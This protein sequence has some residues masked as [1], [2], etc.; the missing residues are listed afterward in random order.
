VHESDVRFTH[1]GMV[2]GTPGYMAPELFSMAE[3]APSHDLYAAGVVAMFALNGPLNLRDGAFRAD[4]LDHHL[5]SVTPK[6]AAVIRKLVAPQ[7]GDR[8][9]DAA[10]VRA[11]LPRVP[12]DYPLSFADGRPLEILD[13]LPP[14]AN[15]A[16]VTPQRAQPGHGDMSMEAIRQGNLK[17]A[18]PGQRTQAQIPSPYPSPSSASPGYSPQTGPRQYTPGQSEAGGQGGAYGSPSVSSPPYGTQS[19]QP[20]QNGAGD[21]GGGPAL[22]GSAQSGGSRLRRARTDPRGMVVMASVFGLLAAVVLGVIVTI[23]LINLFPA[24]SQGGDGASDGGS[25]SAVVAMVEDPVPDL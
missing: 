22:Q 13:Q 21:A 8:Y 10:S 9:Q 7:P 20:Q 11:D 17:Q 18:S 19:A 4:E 12:P 14:L 1:V 16:P 24:D 3:P 2:N 25:S 6:L 15:S 5:R 23:V